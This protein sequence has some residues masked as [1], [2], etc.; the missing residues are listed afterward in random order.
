MI[1]YLN[2]NNV[3]G[4]LEDFSAYL[5]FLGLHPTFITNP[6]LAGI[7]GP[8]RFSTATRFSPA[9]GATVLAGRPPSSPMSE[10]TIPEELL[11]EIL[12]YHFT[13]PEER[14]FEFPDANLPRWRERRGYQGRRSTYKLVSDALVVSK[15]WLRIGTPLLYHSV[16]IWDQKHTRAIAQ[17]LKA[18]PSLGRAIRWLRLEGGLG[19]D[20]HAIAKFTPNIDML[21]MCFRVRASEGVAGFRK[22]LPLL[23][24]TKLYL[25]SSGY[26]RDTK[27]RM[28][29]KALLYVAL[30]NNWISLVSIFII[31]IIVAS[32]VLEDDCSVLQGLRHDLR[33]RSSVEQGSCPQKHHRLFRLLEFYTR[34]DTVWL[35][36][37]DW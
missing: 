5:I 4:H 14:F 1:E 22:A 35:H 10:D 27:A 33:F 12:S 7:Y 24:P 16:T 32:N 8:R 26:G 37:D 31:T 29:I 19:K 9:F 15:R 18:N 3:S 30:E 25:V 11:R 17:L 13:I 36:S 21:L 6:I 23:N 34:L 20:L 28:E 2:R